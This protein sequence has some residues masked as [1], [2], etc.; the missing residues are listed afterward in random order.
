MSICQDCKGTGAKDGIIRHNPDGSRSFVRCW[1]YNGNG[2]EPPY[3]GKP[4]PQLS[5]KKEG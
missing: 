1:T 5:P 3:P 2:L 4:Y